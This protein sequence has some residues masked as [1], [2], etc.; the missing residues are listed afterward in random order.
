M[1]RHPKT[2]NNML[3]QGLVAAQVLSHVLAS[4]HT[5]PGHTVFALKNSRAFRLCLARFYEK[6]AVD[7]TL[8]K[9][10]VSS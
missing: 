7:Q 10:C 6:G 2:R 3:G 4:G 8:V 1:H 9:K 5:C